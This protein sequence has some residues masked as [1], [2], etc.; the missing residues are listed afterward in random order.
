MCLDFTIPAHSFIISAL[1]KVLNR[2]NNLA[3]KWIFPVSN[4]DVTLDCDYF[5]M[6]LV[7]NI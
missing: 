4:P 6:E 7:T 1:K 3:G 2:G 5:V